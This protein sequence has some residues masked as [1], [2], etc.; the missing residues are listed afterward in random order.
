MATGHDIDF[1]DRTPQL[2]KTRKL[3]DVTLLK[4]KYALEHA[5]V[6]PCDSGEIAA[7]ENDLVFLCSGH[8]WHS[9]QKN[10]IKQCDQL[11]FPIVRKK[12][13]HLMRKDLE[14]YKSECHRL[15]AEVSVEFVCLCL[16][17]LYFAFLCLVFFG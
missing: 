16:F 12:I 3:F 7:S 2:I 13:I 14:K 4:Q 10:V 5:T 8:Y 6:A 15:N 1:C 11:K 17:L 9:W